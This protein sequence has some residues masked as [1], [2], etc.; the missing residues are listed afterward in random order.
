MQT[1]M[2][3]V[4]EIIKWEFKPSPYLLPVGAAM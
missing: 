1:E 4:F 3:V 2:D